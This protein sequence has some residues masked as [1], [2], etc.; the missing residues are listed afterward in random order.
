MTLER[1]RNIK[2][3][4][5][6]APYRKKCIIGD[7]H[8]NLFLQ[9]LNVKRL[10]KVKQTYFDVFWSHINRIHIEGRMPNVQDFN[11]NSP[12]HLSALKNN[13]RCT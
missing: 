5:K 11:G 3:I 7:G 12:L 4:E 9:V 2:L 13:V 8:H 1:F 10:A 6:T